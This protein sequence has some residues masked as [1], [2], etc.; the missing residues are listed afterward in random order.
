M[1]I[2]FA[3]GINRKL[4]MKPIHLIK[5]LSRVFAALLF[6][7]TT[8]CLAQE[9]EQKPST[10]SAKGSID[11]L[12]NFIWRGIALDPSP[13]LQP[14]L[15]FG[16][17]VVEFGILGSYSLGGDFDA[18]PVYLKF[19]FDTKIGSFSPMLFNYYYPSRKIPFD[20]FSNDNTGAHTLEAS[21]TYTATVPLQIFVSANV[22]ND[23]ARSTYA[24]AKYK[25][26]VKDKYSLEPFVG[27]SLEEKSP[28]L[29]AY[30]RG[31]TNVGV[32]L[33]RQIAVS[34][35]YSI[36]V[37]VSYS[38][39]TQIRSAYLSARVSFPF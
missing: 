23:T 27:A 37:S 18:T 38:L 36:P 33:A 28:W 22:L 34:E 17:D 5:N 14:S 3:A 6:T 12:S 1:L 24:E 4:E 11:V 25:F 26:K 29:A 32:T 9:S 2:G 20:N 39:H 31:V 7:I 10:F 21:L 8:V 15:M 30:R 16:N 19:T 35:E 13:C